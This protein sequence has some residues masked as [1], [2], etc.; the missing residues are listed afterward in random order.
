MTFRFGML[1]FIVALILR[2]VNICIVSNEV[3]AFQQGDTGMYLQMTKILQDADSLKSI[4]SDDASFL[5]ERAPGYLSY[6]LTIKSV[7]GENPL[8]IVF[9]QA[10][11][12]AF[13]CVLVGVLG[14]SINQ[15]LILPA[16]LLATVNLNMII[17]SAFI[18]SDSLFLL[19]FTGGLIA[20]SFYIRSP[21]FSNA[22]VAGVLFSIALLIRP[23]LLYFP[24][25]LILFFAAIA[26][27]QR[28]R[29]TKVF[30]HISIVALAFVLIN[31]PIFLRNYNEFGYAA[32]VSQTGTHA[33]NWVYPQVNEFANGVPR[34]QSV[35]EMRERQLDYR[36]QQDPNIDLSN[37]FAANEEMK[38]VA[39]SAL[40]DLG[41][42]A[43][44]KGWAMG[45]MI[46][47]SAPS[48][49]AS[50]IIRN[51]ERPSF[52][53]TL[54]NNP[55]H[56]IWNY[57]T[58]NKVFTMSILPVMALTLLSRFFAFIGLFECYHNRRVRE[59]L[60]PTEQG[61]FLILVG[62]YV[63]AVTGPVV[64]VKYR[65]LLEPGLDILLAIGLVW[66]YDILRKKLKSQ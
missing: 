59:Q 12:D 11:I 38:K 7:F 39:F 29:F 30:S 10:V 64:G 20:S 14:G 63:L 35:D 53:N 22:L 25:V 5:T 33:L 52:T 44:L 47:L 66:T 50:P 4:S 41:S 42:I 61:L 18:L 58:V 62:A 46:N 49:I 24:P 45:A 2:V 56:K 40:S 37:P 32:Y 28:F 54:G 51:M 21:S 19:P 34:E 26:W 13:V 17:H 3:E 57:L 23:V 36:S 65:L 9:G 1:I 55:V 60:V 15:R 16:S 6:L 27:Q 43:L 48:I 31:G 8:F